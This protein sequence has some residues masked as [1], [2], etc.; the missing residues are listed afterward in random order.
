MAGARPQ[1]LRVTDIKS[2]LLNVAQSSQYL[3]TLSIPAAVRSKVSDLSDLDLDNIALSCS[4][5]N[6]PG[7]SL[8]TH[9]V[10]ND[11]QGVTEKMA[12]RRI[13]DDVLGL[14]FY[15]D[16]NYN[17]I[18]LFERWIDHISGITDTN[19]YKSPYTNQRVSYPQT[20]KRDIFVTK[21]EK[22]LFSDES[23]LP[24]NRLEY[25]FVQAFP[26]D[27]TAMPVSYDEASVLKCSISFS[28][29]R[30]LVDKKN[31]TT[32]GLSL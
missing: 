27:I 23:K 7:S 12:Y 32:V 17:I 29:I 31:D 2:R 28:F 9:D 18:K 3:L 1:K 22:D 5:A 4:E 26:R 13:Y 11:Y 14:T 25:T 10:T 8:A 30:Y 15:V 20:Y 16:R 19:F 6:L 24:K 21:F